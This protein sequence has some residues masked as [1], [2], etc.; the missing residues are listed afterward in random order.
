LFLGFGVGVLGFAP[1]PQTPK[2]QSPIP[3]P[4][5]L[6]YFD[7]ISDVLKFNYSFY[8]DKINKMKD[9]T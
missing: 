2:P 3:N 9:N 5:F 1:Q 4:Q 8:F 6:F 7:K